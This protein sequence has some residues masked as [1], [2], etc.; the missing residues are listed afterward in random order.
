M[1]EMK[2]P[3][4]FDN[5]RST[6]TARPAPKPA[7]AAQQ[8]R[9]APTRRVVAVPAK[10]ARATVLRDDREARRE[11]RRAARERRRYERAE[12]KRFTVRSR[13]R[14]TAVLVAGGLVVVLAG[15]LAVAVFSPI[16][17]LRTI[18]VQGASR[19][20][21]AQVESA[22]DDQLGTPLALL[23]QGRITSEL[24]AFPLIRSFVTEVVPPSTL[25][26]SITEREPVAVMASGA[27]WNL[28]DPAGVV[29]QTL[30]QQPQNLPVLDLSSASTDSVAFDA[31]TGVI[32]GLPDPLRKRVTWLTATTSDD[33]EF[34]LSGMAG[35]RVFWGSAEDND[36]KAVVLAALIKAQNKSDHIEYNVSS[37]TSPFVTELA[38]VPTDPSNQSAAPTPSGTPA[39]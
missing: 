6:M 5:S 30:D 32:V 38:D 29:V 21:A 24:S 8:Q 22:I 7:P 16:L 12:V 18:T 23:D 19:V 28:V 26:V 14:R 27:G 4:G 31:A 25:V 17:S 35:Q 20:D 39:P 37:P 3:Q 13:R 9:A 33:V 15:M 10:K 11:L 36:V 1:P 34:Q 2:R